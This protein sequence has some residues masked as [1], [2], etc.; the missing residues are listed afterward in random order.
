M[1]QAPSPPFLSEVSNL[2]GKYGESGEL[3]GIP[4]I[5]PCL[6]LKCLGSPPTFKAP[7]FPSS[8]IGNEF[9]YYYSNSYFHSCN[10]VKCNLT[11]LTTK[12]SADWQQGCLLRAEVISSAQP[13]HTL[14]WVFSHMAALILQVFFPFHLIGLLPPPPLPIF[15]LL[16]SVMGA[17]MPNIRAHSWVAWIASDGSA[18]QSR[19]WLTRFK[20]NPLDI[21]GTQPPF[22]NVV[23]FL[24]NTKL[25]ESLVATILKY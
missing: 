7:E 3:T 8:H 22:H 14:T 25:M 6:G 13:G 5:P 1:N 21:P 9:N 20:W 15:P 10:V 17:W 2:F 12:S 16:V 4:W 24:L 23:K 19:G 18:T 11:K